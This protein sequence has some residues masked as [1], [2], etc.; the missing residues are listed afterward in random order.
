MIQEFNHYAPIG[1]FDSGIGGLSIL[2]HLKQHLPFETFVYLSDRAYCPYGA[3]GDAF[4]QGR[5]LD[6]THYLLQ[7]HHI[8]A[9]VV[10]CNTATAA[11]IYTLRTQFS[12]MPII[13][14]EPAIKP[15]LKH[16]Q[17]KVITVFATHGTV[18]SDK[19]KHLNQQLL[20]DYPTATIHLQPCEGLADAIDMHY[21]VD[22]NHPNI[23]YWVK[24]YLNEAGLLNTNTLKQSDNHSD[25]IILGCTH[26]PLIKPV[27]AQY[28]KDT[29]TIIDN[30]DAVAQQLSTQLLKH[31]LLNVNSTD[32]NHSDLFLSST[33]TDNSVAI[34][35]DVSLAQYLNIGS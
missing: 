18:F 23:H 3:K 5:S 28:L 27:F 33:I 19:V 32:N 14:I 12:T 29:I 26:Y 20:I 31:G 13:G 7:H 34:K 30:G 15:A 11:A 1:V 24:H 9:L 16:S 6:I 25:T 10:A 2:K 4:I 17:T 21:C 35:E 8:K 22:L